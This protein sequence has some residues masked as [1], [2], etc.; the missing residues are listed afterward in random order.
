[1]HTK[2]HQLRWESNLFYIFTVFC[3]QKKSHSPKLTKVLYYRLE[4]IV[5]SWHRIIIMH[6]IVP[7]GSTVTHQCRGEMAGAHNLSMGE[8]YEQDGA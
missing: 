7:W 4:N 2:V 8:R 1:M 3:D 5:A 6:P